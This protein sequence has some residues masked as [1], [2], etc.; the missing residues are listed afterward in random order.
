MNKFVFLIYQVVDFK[1]QLKQLKQLRKKLRKKEGKDQANRI[2]KEGVYLISIG[3]NDY[4]MPL[5]YNP[6]L[7]QSISMEDYVGMVIGN[8]T[9]V[10]K[11]LTKLYVYL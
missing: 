10:L 1:M 4:L 5:V 7:F 6:A 3:S 2:I 11:V 9:T 8:I